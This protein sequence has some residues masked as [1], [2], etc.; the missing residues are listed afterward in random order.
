MDRQEAL[1]LLGVDPTAPE[2]AVT[3]AY[4][5]RSRGLKQR[6]LAADS[7]SSARET[8]RE[9]RR[10]QQARDTLVARPGPWTLLGVAEGANTAEIQEAYKSRSR[11]L[12]G[13]ILAASTEEERAGHRRSI[14]ELRAAL[15]A[16]LGPRTPSPSPGLSATKM[17]DLPVMRPSATVSATTP[18][19]GARVGLAPGRTL[20]GRYEIR[21]SIGAGGM[22]EVYRAHDRMQER[23]IAV[24]A[25]LPAL[26][27]DRQARERFLAEARIS[28]ELSHPNI[29]NVFDVH[30]EGSLHF[31]SME[32]LEGRT[33]REEIARRR[34]RKRPFRVEEAV[35]MGEDLCGA[36]A[37]AHRFTVHRDV[38]PENVFLCS[39]GTLK[40]M[41]FGIARLLKSSQLT[42][43][44][45]AMGTAYY[46]APEQLTG[47]REIDGRADQYAVAV[48]L[49]ELL[50]G[51]L[52]A[53]R[54]A[55]VREL[56]KDCPRSLSLALD[57]ALSPRREGRF[58]NIEAFGRALRRAPLLAGVRPG[59]LVAALLLLVL[60]G[61]AAMV[62]WTWRESLASWA[63]GLFGD[64]EAEPKAARELAA[65][66]E[67]RARV[68]EVLDFAEPEAL[69]RADASVVE[70]EAHAARG[71]HADAH[72]RYAE[73][74]TLFREIDKK[75]R[76]RKQSASA[77][78]AAE[79]RKS[80]SRARAV[81]AREEA[82]RVE[83]DLRRHGET[84]DEDARRGASALANAETLM[85]AEEYERAE[86]AFRESRESLKTALS[87]VESTARESAKSA[88]LD[89]QALVAQTRKLGDELDGSHR[90]LADRVEELRRE[91]GRSEGAAARRRGGGAADPEAMETLEV[92][93]AQLGVFDRMLAACE[94]E[95][96][97]G[98]A[99]ADAKAKL[100]DAEAEE[101]REEYSKAQALYRSG[102]GLLGQCICD[103][104]RIAASE[105]AKSA[106][107]GSDAALAAAQAGYA[108]GR[109]G[110]AGRPEQAAAHFAEAA[111]QFRSFRA[112]QERTLFDSI[113]ARERGKRC[114]SCGASGVCSACKGRRTATVSCRRCD[115]D[116]ETE[117]DC[118][119]C[120][121]DGKVECPQCQGSGDVTVACSACRGQGRVEC[122]ECRGA[123]EV[124]C[125][126]CKG[127]PEKRCTTCRGTGRLDFGNGVRVVCTG[128]CLGTG[129]ITCLNCKMFGSRP[130]YKK[131]SDCRGKGRQ[132]C[133]ECDG[134]GK[135]GDRCR[136]CRGGEIT[137]PECR[138][139]RKAAERCHAC[140]GAG[141]SEENC[142][143]CRGS[144]SCSSCGGAGRRG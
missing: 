43:T 62:G 127:E 135:V 108:K 47:S 18:E 141:K 140:G 118:D 66:R 29:V 105:I 32:L 4:K 139:R 27:S 106:G 97:H 22:G 111:R 107:K 90:D 142:P 87:R 77:A 130:G 67:A 126:S 24:K 121:G 19:G 16:L 133:D 128:G 134:D 31:L 114:S 2:Q 131:C 138:G 51:E 42:M 34:E 38:K 8:R 35:K 116:G 46:M 92:A 3:E 81:Q 99:L 5:A 91:V 136:N 58:E 83:E 129:T 119:T 71:D 54:A 95:V 23:D 98:P 109:E 39:D 57:R 69:A 100:G 113:S 125:S 28:T 96:I 6:I 144:G 36:L 13:M 1:E 56:R 14:E 104:E 20:A 85:E 63:Q 86:A 110:M 143:S 88:R 10:L 137:C 49:Y 55:S 89:L 44:G 59:R 80:A 64:P 120:T 15:E 9:L 82:K 103:F 101:T 94:K 25:L 65:A 26:L 93:R 41:D 60:V 84:S 21:Q 74:T 7:E 123:G 132:E 45:C 76:A 61:G 12:K 72:G 70:G 11:T 75:A 68:E 50:T 124:L 37:Y 122:D 117:R 30:Q 79:I 48:V 102:L 52:P 53:G 78:E 17:A 73:A 40:L 115:G 112:A 33:L